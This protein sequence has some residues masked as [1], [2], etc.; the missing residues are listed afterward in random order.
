ME[1]I[2]STADF[3]VFF[4]IL[5]GVMAVGLWVGRNDGSS[6]QDYYLAGKDTPWWAV[7]GS[8]FG[9]NVS[10]NHMVGMMAVG[11]G[12]GFVISHLEITAI[13]GLL[14][15][16]YFFLPVYR[17][18]HIF[19]LSDYLNRR[20]DDRSRVA[21]AGIMVT[22]I[23]LVMMLPAFYLG[24]RAVNIL[25]VD[26]AEILQAQYASQLENTGKIPSRDLNDLTASEAEARTEV[27]DAWEKYGPICLAQKAGQFTEATYNDAYAELYPEGTPPPFQEI[28]NQIPSIEA[29]W[30]LLKRVEVDRKLYIWGILIMALVTGAYTI[31]G[32]LRAVIITDVIQ[33]V[34]ILLG[35]LIVAW[36]TFNH[37]LIG[38]WSMM[39]DFDQNKLKEI[40]EGRDLMHLYKP[41][42][43]PKHPWTGMLSGVLVLHFYYWGA[44]Q[45]IVQ[46]A[47]A[48]RS[49]KDARTG[50]IAAGFVKLLIPFI[51]I[52]TGIAA[53]YLFQQ[54]MPG[55]QLAG[56]TAFPMLMREV[57][58]PL[59]VPGLVGLVAAGLIGAIL[60]SVDSMMNSAATLIT[61]D[62]YK[63]F[64]N[65]EAS[66][67]KLVRLGKVIIGILV[68]GSA[69]L[70]IVVFDPNADEPFMNYVLGHQAKLVS[71]LVA[72]FMVGMLWSRATPTAGFVSIIT[73]VVVSYGLPSLYALVTAGEGS[74]AKEIVMRFGTSLNPFH[75]VFIAF[76]C[77]LAANVITSLATQPNDDK[78][79]YTWVGLK[80]MRESD[81]QHF[82]MKLLG[83]VLIFILLAV[84]M[85]GKIISPMGAGVLGAIWT[86]M[87]FLDSLFKVV[88]SAAAKGRAYSFLRE[89]LFWAG[90]LA[91]SAVFMMYHFA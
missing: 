15:L 61:F 49:L 11:F 26:K 28:K 32:G 41:M 74:I 57:V 63:R 6:A 81:L 46:R 85:T 39:I 21:Y 55:V 10:A 37:N 58:A 36:C 84:L 70:T 54:L 71:G 77:A 2:L 78:A 48:A 50:I 88:L 65:P 82:G 76:L 13:A 91:S 72:A 18:L 17:K 60:S 29:K 75:A 27:L 42:D 23:V 31:V 69:I 7:A 40:V 5:F 68:L 22:I 87:M 79:K 83:S 33:S 20:F 8:I 56:D 38:S 3:I 16:C 43:D 24:S 19:T 86:F 73:G 47:L 25:L 12:A 62:G 89:D 51:S 66:D 52:G 4:G 34:L 35:M 64:V 45:F 44:N 30:G 14:L 1:G 80:I 90:L 59:A 9:S 67:E 53:Y